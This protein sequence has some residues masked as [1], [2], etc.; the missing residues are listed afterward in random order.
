[1]VYGSSAG[2]PPESLSKL[3]QKQLSQPAEPWVGDRFDRAEY[4]CVISLLSL[5]QFLWSFK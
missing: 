5:A 1:V 4:L 2:C 3:G